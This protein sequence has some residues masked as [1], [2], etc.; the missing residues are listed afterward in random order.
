MRR[1]AASLPVVAAEVV[2]A[3]QVPARQAWAGWF[4]GALL[5]NPGGPLVSGPEQALLVLGP[6]RSGKTTS[7]VVPNVLTAPGAVVTTSTKD[8]V[9]A[10]TAKARALRGRA[11]LFDPSGTVAPGALTSLRWSPL[12]GCER[13]SIAVARAHALASAAQPA[14]GLV[15]STH[16]TERA[17]ALLGPLFHSAA[18]GGRSMASVLRWVQRRDLTE[19]LD[20]ASSAGGNELAADSIEG[21][22]GTE[23]RERSGIFS[24]AANI[25]AAYRLPEALETASQTNFDAEAFVRS[26]DTIYICAPASEQELLAPVV[27]AFL[28]MV[29]RA[30]YARE[31]GWPPVAFVLDEVANIAPLPGL[32]ALVSEGGSQGLVSLACLQDLSQARARWGERAEGFLTLFGAKLVLPGIADLRTLQLVS[33]L[34]GEADVTYTSV[35]RPADLLSAWVSKSVPH[36]TTYLQ[37]QP[38]DRPGRGSR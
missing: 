23:E 28:D 5:T 31:R 20:L 19:P 4:M 13:W 24:T 35:T 32:P 8:D 12:S 11:W 2:P 1:K 21:V 7:V 27:V 18:L 25:L 22:M 14:R 10:W 37:R 34:A 30:V 38:V 9:V 17:E 36:T 33:A 15:D 16:W 6:P 26:S 3:Q 29:R